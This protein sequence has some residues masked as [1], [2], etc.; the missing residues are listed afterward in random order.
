[1]GWITQSLELSSVLGTFNSTKQHRTHLGLWF[2]SLLGWGSQTLQKTAAAITQE[3]QVILL[4]NVGLETRETIKLK[5]APASQCT[6]KREC[7][8]SSFLCALK[9]GDKEGGEILFLLI[10]YLPRVRITQASSSSINISQK[11]SCFTPCR[12]IPA[13]PSW[14][15]PALPVNSKCSCRHNLL[16]QQKHILPEK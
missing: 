14:A 11:C 7:V 16:Y 1:M 9:G 2:L 13:E 15:D 10:P 6:N 4:I 8:L 3:C 12:I 5:P